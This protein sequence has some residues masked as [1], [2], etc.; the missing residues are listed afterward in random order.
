MQVPKYTMYDNV[1]SIASSHASPMLP[2][3]NIVR[4]TMVMGKNIAPIPSGVNNLG[5]I[6][7]DY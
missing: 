3:A 7:R 1:K 5:N 6:I 4:K 2:T